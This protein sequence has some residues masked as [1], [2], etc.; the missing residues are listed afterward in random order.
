M[1]ARVAIVGIGDGYVL[2]FFF[3]FW[4][5]VLEESVSVDYGRAL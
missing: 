5:L 1:T 2:L 4:E 3:K